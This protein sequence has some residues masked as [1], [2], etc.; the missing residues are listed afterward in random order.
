MGNKAEMRREETQWEK[1]QDE[2]MLRKMKCGE[3]GRKKDKC[4]KWAEIL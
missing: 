3:K 4:E 2:C 1:D